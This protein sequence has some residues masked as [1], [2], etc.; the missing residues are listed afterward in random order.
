MFRIAKTF[1]FSAAHHLPHLP[2][3]HQCRRPHG[4]NYT[5]T[6]ELAAPATNS[7]S[8]VLDYG[9]LVVVKADLD[10]NFDHRDLN[11]LVPMPTTAE[12][13]AVY[14]YQR[15]QEELPQLVAVRVSETPK[16]WAEYRDEP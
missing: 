10:N 14:F 9:E 7:D 5:V 6:V 12:N 4:H 13:L 2:E 1:E 3:G 11:A 8:F 15:W 16:T